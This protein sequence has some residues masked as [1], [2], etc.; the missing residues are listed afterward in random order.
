MN[1]ISNILLIS[2]TSDTTAASTCNSNVVGLS[3]EEEQMSAT[4]FSPIM[5]DG[6]DDISRV[7]VFL[8][9]LE[10]RELSASVCQ[11]LRLDRR[12]VV[13]RLCTLLR[14]LPSC[15]SSCDDVLR[16]LEIVSSVSEACDWWNEAIQELVLLVTVLM[17]DGK[18]LSAVA[19]AV[20]LLERFVAV[21]ACIILYY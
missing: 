21:R 8:E 9:V 20:W 5:T 3:V 7:S 11:L 13:G 19:L 2:S 1:L 6:V 18:I 10:N 14:S 12:Q 15:Q 4:V 17:N 16:L